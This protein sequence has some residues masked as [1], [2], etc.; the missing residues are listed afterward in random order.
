M[1]QRIKKSVLELDAY[2]PG[3][4]PRVE[5]L[6]KLNTNEN[7]YPPSPKVAQAIHDLAVEPLR[8]Y[9]D[10]VCL[11][12]RTRIAE[13]HRCSVE[14]IF[15][16][17]G[18]DEILA[19]CT[20]AYVEDTG[21]IGY[22]HPSYSL[23]RVLA[24]IR[25]VEKKPVELGPDFEW[26]M[27][28][29]YECSLFFLTFPNAP[30]GMIYPKAKIAAFCRRNPGVVLIDEAY[31]DFSRE[32]C[33]ALALKEENVLVLRTLSKSFS[34]AG[35]RVGYVAGPAPL[36]DAM[37]KLK[38]SYNV[39]RIAQ[40][41]AMAALSDLEYMRTNAA[42]ICATRAKLAEGLARRGFRVYPSE[43]NFLWV[44]PPDGNAKAL[45]ERLRAGNILVR[46][47]PGERTGNG[48]RI[49]VGT[50]REIDMLLA[51]LDKGNK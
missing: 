32:N 47:F 13:I 27:P 8:L 6:I 16:G 31:V 7:P 19:L 36:V 12:L 17:N 5:G 24:D 26:A 14:N 25:C 49:T 11:A 41:A 44:R 15:V 43:S 34:L 35:L 40:A 18:S 2:T 42:K 39:D 29:N 10:P 20:R 33:M 1:N 51:M 48:L 28:D 21:S 37:Y 30:T 50:D 23:Y 38:D 4:Q 45:F 9:P 3:E 46:F 22:F